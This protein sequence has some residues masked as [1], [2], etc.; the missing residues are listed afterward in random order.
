M[1][2]LPDRIDCPFSVRRGNRPEQDRPKKR[3][4]IVEVQGLGFWTR[5]RLP[6]TPLRSERSNTAWLRSIAVYENEFGIMLDTLGYGARQVTPL[7]FRDCCVIFCASPF[8]DF[9]KKDLYS[10]MSLLPRSLL[11]GGSL[12]FYVIN[13]MSENNIDKFIS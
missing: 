5:V 4:M 3:T 10:F 13:S 2:K 1:M 6:S 9:H 8:Y 12:N 7:K 11:R